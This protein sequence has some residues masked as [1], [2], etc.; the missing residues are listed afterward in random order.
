MSKTGLSYKGYNGSCE[1][2]FED[3]CLHG[4]ILFIDD[5]IT[6]EGETPSQ[7]SEAFKAAVDRYCEHCAKTGRPANKPYRG[8][9]NVRTGP[10]IHKR[11]A[12]AAH[13]MGIGLNDFVVKSI[14]TQLEQSSAKKNEHVHKLVCIV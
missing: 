3:E 6:F 12:A 1:V 14:N 5:L 9:F 7:L 2:N 13:S 11:I 10:E 8:S 4:K